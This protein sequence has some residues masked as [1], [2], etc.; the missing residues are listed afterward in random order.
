RPEFALLSPGMYIS[1]T[2]SFSAE[3]VKNDG[4]W[5]QTGGTVDVTTP[6]G[7]GVFTSVDIVQQV[8][9]VCTVDTFHNYGYSY[10]PMGKAGELP[11]Q[12]WDPGLYISGTADFNA[13]TVNNYAVVEHG[14]GSMTVGKFNNYGGEMYYVGA[15]PA[16]V[17]EGMPGLYVYG[18]ADFDASVLVNYG[19]VSHRDGR[20]AA[21]RV[22][23]YAGEGGYFPAGG[24]QPAQ[25][26]Y[27]EGIHVTGGADFA[28]D[29]VHNRGSFW[30]DG[31]TIS[32]RAGGMGLFVN[33]GEAGGYLYSSPGTFTMGVGPMG[34][35]TAPGADPASA[36][37]RDHL[38]NYGYF[39]YFDGVFTGKYEHRTGFE[40]F[41]QAQDFTAGAGIVNWSE[42][43]NQPWM[44]I[45][46]DGPGLSNY[47]QF[48]MAGGTLGG[49]GVVN[50]A[51]GSLHTYL[52]AIVDN[53]L[54]NYGDVSTE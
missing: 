37:F 38:I 7:D 35:S 21:D 6:E 32:D 42:M 51:L 24:E 20:L 48:E 5:L 28:A 31:G 18:T 8:G 45:T 52:H 10:Y 16:S 40:G 41:V 33:Y 34:T 11:D 4:Y 9:G 26:M 17:S 53:D 13:T 25:S 27:F 12:P 15:A 49:G 30:Q 39:Y 22:H 44:D 43:T 19:K 29:E 47:G 54:T 50:E 23:N 3:I 1:G 36:E 14:G 2:A 46:A